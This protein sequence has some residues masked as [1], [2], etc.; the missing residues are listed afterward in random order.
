MDDTLLPQIAVPDDSSE[1][2]KK[3][4]EETN[5]HLL[6]LVKRTVKADPSLAV[7]RF[8]VLII[9]ALVV[10][11]STIALIL[12]A[13]NENGWAAAASATGMIVSLSIVG[14]MNPLQ[15][16]E[17]DIIIRRWSDIIISGWAADL[18]EE[19]IST[20][21]ATK[22]ATERYAV[23]AAAYSTMTSKTLDALSALVAVT[24]AIDEDSTDDETDSLTVTPISAQ[25]SAQGADLSDGI[26][27]EAKGGSGKYTFAATDLP[28]GLSIPDAA[29]GV[30]KGS[31]AADAEVKE[32]NVKIVVTETLDQGATETPQ[33]ASLEFVWTVT[34]AKG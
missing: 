3:A 19:R 1:D 27:I 22:R 21:T 13:F 30:I 15:T 12:S 11:G 26:T 8:G 17:R 32:W 33:S 6:E 23:L 20:G 4:A 10:T 28:S 14:L 25:T 18:A 31:I 16:I 34:A 9:L 5:E 29:V 2:L 7:I 24:S